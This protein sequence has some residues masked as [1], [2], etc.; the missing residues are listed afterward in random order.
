MILQAED[1]VW[2]GPTKKEGQGSTGS[3]YLDFLGATGDYIEW[4]FSW[5]TEGP[6]IIKFRYTLA[7]ALALALSRP[8]ELKINGVVFKS[9]LD[10]HWTDGWSSW[11]IMEVEVPL[12][13]GINSVRITAI[14]QGGPNFDYL[15]VQRLASQPGSGGEN[16]ATTF[17]F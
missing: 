5:D 4:K 2:N 10:F 9:R 7:K 17:S 12:V 11:Q 1:A 13:E 16:P 6:A 8:L 15:I 14:G 3:G